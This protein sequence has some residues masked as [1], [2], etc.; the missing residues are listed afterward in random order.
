[1]FPAGRSSQEGEILSG[2][3]QSNSMSE[4]NT[5]PV[6]TQCN[7]PSEHPQPES[8]KLTSIFV[9]GT[10]QRGQSRAKCWPRNPI[11]IAPGVVHARLVNFGPYPAMVRSED[12]ADRVYGEVWTF[13]A[14]DLKATLKVLDWIEGFDP[15]GSFSEYVRRPVEAKWNE[16]AKLEVQPPCTDRGIYGPV[17]SNAS[18]FNLSLSSNLHEA[19]ASKQELA[20]LRFDATWASIRCWAYWCIEPWKIKQ[21]KAINHIDSPDGQ[22]LYVW[23]ELGEAN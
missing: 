9:Y 12:P 8:Q 16:D 15:A 6:L 23:P 17:S 19:N 21:A 10:L 1:M 13:Q 2:I 5:D 11:W 7:E 20:L 14:A 18:A 3:S 4:I 22:K